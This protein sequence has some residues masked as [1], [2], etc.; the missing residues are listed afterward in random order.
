M[1][2]ALKKKASKTIEHTNKSR[3]RYPTKRL[4]LPSIIFVG[5]VT[6]IPFILTIFY[7]LHNWNLMRP[8]R[9]L[10]FIGFSNYTAILS[11]PVFWTVLKNSFLLTVGALIICLITG[12]AFALLMNRDFIG[13]GIVRTMLVSPFFVMPTVSA[14]IWKTIL[15]NPNFGFAGYFAK[16]LGL[17][18]IDFL[19]HYP[20]QSIVL[21]VSWMW[22]PFFML[23]LLAGLQSLPEELLEAAQLDGANKVQ[24]FFHVIIPHLL[25]Y[26]EVVILL[27]LMFILQVFG[28][29]FVTTSGG[30][31]YASTN[32]P[33]YTYRIGFQSW[34][35]G[36]AAAVGVITAVLT[37]IIMTILF[38]I[39][40]RTFREE[41]A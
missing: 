12:L 13:K 5:V 23:I 8:D 29:I 41:A 9:G 37:I 39:I 6:Q 34:D 4:L 36:S 19:A 21:V 7:S 32:L 3:R 11:E 31:G 10:T 33:F 26:F 16:I 24:Q 30:P 38:F 14:I 27:G 28:E 40:R 1:E 25:R 17:P 15:M 35:V 22:I 2:M 18:A 20:L